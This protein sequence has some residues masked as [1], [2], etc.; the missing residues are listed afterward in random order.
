MN[1]TLSIDEKLL[2]RAQEVARRRCISLDQMIAGYLH[3]LTSVPEHSPEE[4][5]QELEEFWA[6]N[7][8]TSEPISWTREEI[9]ERSSIR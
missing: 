4:T 1:V 5:I 9:H 2:A 8:G 6:Q 3:E 7:K